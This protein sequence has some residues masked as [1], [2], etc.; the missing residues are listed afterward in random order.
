MRWKSAASTGRCRGRADAQY[1]L[2]GGFLM[3]DDFHGS[4]Q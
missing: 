2:K 3:V 4:V 1:L